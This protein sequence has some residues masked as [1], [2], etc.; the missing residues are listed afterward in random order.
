M[1]YAVG[2]VGYNMAAISAVIY[3][4]HP[5][6]DNTYVS[7]SLHPKSDSSMR[8]MPRLAS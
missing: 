8:T 7:P 1:C 2:V 3:D 4:C 5:F 6:D